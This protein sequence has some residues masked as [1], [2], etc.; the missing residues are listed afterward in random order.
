M[1]EKQKIIDQTG[2]EY[3]PLTKDE[4]VMNNP[5][6][7]ILGKS[8]IIP[9]QENTEYYED[10]NIYIN[11]DCKTV[12]KGIV[13]VHTDD[14]GSRKISINESECRELYKY[15]KKIMEAPLVTIKSEFYE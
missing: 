5:G 6:M 12:L 13:I 1:K 10:E 7:L 15:M 3:T 11:K 2:E 4:V 8:K 14:N 9:N